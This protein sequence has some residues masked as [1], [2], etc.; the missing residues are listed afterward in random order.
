MDYAFYCPARQ[1]GK[2][3]WQNGLTEAA[4]FRGE[5]VALCS[6][7]GTIV[8]EHKGDYISVEFIPY[9]EKKPTLDEHSFI[10]DDYL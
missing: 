10:F 9:E 1:Y 5:R 4:L 8:A 6:M 7:R 2:R 3:G